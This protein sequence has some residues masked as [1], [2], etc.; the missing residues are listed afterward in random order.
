MD[1]DVNN[2]DALLTGAVPPT[3]GFEY[4]RGGL[5]PWG[6]IIWVGLLLFAVRLLAPPNLLDNDQERPASYVLDAVQNGHWLCQRDLAGEIAS[7]PPLWTWLASVITLVCG[8]IN[9]LA[10][11]L[12]GA[13][14]AIG[15]ACAIFLLGRKP[16]GERA[17]LLGALGCMLS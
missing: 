4:P 5:L 13:L 10:L 1:A 14:A 17:A 16:F 12:P 2:V 9:L 6:L 3:A 8:R 7:K 15:T 11:Y